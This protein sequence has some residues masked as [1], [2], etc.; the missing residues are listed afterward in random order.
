M[1]KKAQYKSQ[2]KRSAIPDLK[3]PRAQFDMSHTVKTAFDASKIIPF[4]LQ[5]VVPGD[6]HNVDVTGLL[7]LST[8]LY[9]IMDNLYMDVHFF[10]VPHRIVW[11]NFKKMMGEQ[12][13][14][15]DSVD[16]TVPQIIPAKH[17]LGD[18]YDH[19]GIPPNRS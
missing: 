8:P 11:A 2:E 16:Y 3:I 14:P 5:E 10:F 13:S 17:G 7:R 18:T 9:P 19:Y 12:D 4:Y 15:A 6:T 1:A